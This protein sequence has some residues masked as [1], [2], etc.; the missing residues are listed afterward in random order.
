[1]EH[2]SLDSVGTYDKKFG[3][4]KKK[5][6]NIIYRVSTDGT[7]QNSI[8]QVLDVG[9]SAKKLLCRV[10]TPRTWQR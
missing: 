1:M 8:Y 2:V 10:L 4:E 9:H 7:R 3:W 5:N 6:K